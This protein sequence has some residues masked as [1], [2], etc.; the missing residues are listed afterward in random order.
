[1]MYK[2][3]LTDEIIVYCKKGKR[4]VVAAK[5]LKQ[6]GYQNVSFVEGGWKAWELTYP[7]LY[8]KNLNADSHPVVADE[9]GC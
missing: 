4:S 5:L 8:D 6:I 7:L 9:G 2:P 1:M 3:E